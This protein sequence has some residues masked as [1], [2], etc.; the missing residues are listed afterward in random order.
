[1]KK[2][3][4]LIITLFIPNIVSAASFDVGETTVCGMSNLP[5]TLPDFTSTL[6][7]MIK[8]IIP[9]ILIIM[10]MVDMFSAMSASDQDKMKK[11][12]KKLI[13]RAIAAII[14]FFIFAIVQFAFKNVGTSDSGQLSN[15]LNCLINNKN[16]SSSNIKRVDVEKKGKYCEE[17]SKDECPS[18]DSYGYTCI[19]KD[20]VCK[21]KCE[22]YSTESPCTSHKSC[23]WDKYHCIY[24]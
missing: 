18:T 14:I 21:G 9:V 10:G 8:V 16:C 24:N 2:K 20:S 11:A 6:Y 1:M 17:Y 23:K 4:I 13:T 3:L 22:E 5:A 7:T 19:V 15:C 12:Q